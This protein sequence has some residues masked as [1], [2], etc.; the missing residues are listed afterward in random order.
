M[1][2]VCGFG[3]SEKSKENKSK[4]KNELAPLAQM[5]LCGRALTFTWARICKS[6]QT[7]RGYS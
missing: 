6:A 5:C 3:G 4:V 2:D 7:K 1:F